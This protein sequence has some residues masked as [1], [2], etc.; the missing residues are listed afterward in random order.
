MSAAVKPAPSG[1]GCTQRRQPEHTLWYRTL[2]TNLET[3]LAFA[4][5]SDDAAPPATI[6]QAFRRYLEC[7][8]LAHGFARAFCDAYGHDFLIGFSCPPR[9]L[10]S[11]RKGRAV[12]PSCNTRRM[13]ATAAHLTDH[14]WPS[15]PVRQLLAAKRNPKHAKRWSSPR[16]SACAISCR[17]TRPCRVPSCGSWCARWSAACAHTVPVAAPRPGWGRWCSSTASAP[18]L[19]S[20]RTF[21]ATLWTACSTVSS[22]PSADGHGF[23]TLRRHPLPR[24]TTGNQS[25]DLIGVLLYNHHA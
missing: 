20:T 18:P 25:Q 12:C 24:R 22:W 3:W 1:T 10:P 14:V 13:V 2:Q 11:G 15:L 17:T 9:G 23:Q 7:G 8:I 6:E 4:A 19:T 21:T 5:G 16:R